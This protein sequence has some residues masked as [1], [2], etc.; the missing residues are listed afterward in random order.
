MGAD[1]SA[2]RLSSA[3]FP[4]FFLL[5]FIRGLPVLEAMEEKVSLSSISLHLI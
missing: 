4:H 3:R 2:I 1:S 5:P